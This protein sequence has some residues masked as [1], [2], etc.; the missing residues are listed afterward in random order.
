M[1]LALSALVDQLNVRTQAQKENLKT[2]Q[3][4]RHHANVTRA[5]PSMPD[6]NAGT[7]SAVLAEV[8]NAFSTRSAAGSSR[9]GESGPTP[10]GGSGSGVAEDSTAQASAGGGRS[11]PNASAGRTSISGGPDGQTAAPSE[12]GGSSSQVAG[13]GTQADP[14]AGGKDPAGTGS[15]GAGDSR[16]FRNTVIAAVLGAASTA[17]LGGGGY[18]ISNYL[19][20]GDEGDHVEVRDSQYPLLDWL[21][22]H[23]HHLSKDEQ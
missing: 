8:L 17:A 13:G 18:L 7:S 22:E 5:L 23:G 1:N 9:S 14:G 21:Q 2:H 11:N 19:F 20:G 3:W 15:G 12:G 16:S 6:E 10:D 4:Y